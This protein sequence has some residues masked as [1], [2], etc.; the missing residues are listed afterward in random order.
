VGLPLFENVLFAVGTALKVFL[1]VLVFY[2]RLYRRLPLF[3]VYAVLLLL[4]VAVEW[5]AYHKWGYTSRPAWYAY[6]SALGVVLMA[7]GLTVAE[8]CWVS[9]RNYAG[10]WSFVSKFLALIAVV[11][12]ASAGVAAARN[13]YWIVAFVLT[14]ERGVELA[15]S[16]ILVALFA[17]SVRY[18]IWLEPVE[19]NIAVGLA[20]YSMFQMLNRMFMTPRMAP[21][22]P[23]W[24][25]VRI[26]CFDVA[27]VLWIVPMLKPL[28]APPRP[29][30]IREEASLY[31]LPRLL[32]RMQKLTSE[33]KRLKRAIRK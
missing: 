21:Y 9:L 6:W 11:L 28:A 5:W 4:E 25:S 2:R 8:L 1:C 32:D 16:V 10:L 13:T 27:M 24:E 29:P 17:V 15:V 7:R 26:G 30:L 3:T 33:L 18:R 12:L 22:F 20:L 23:W 14:T 19:R 31:L